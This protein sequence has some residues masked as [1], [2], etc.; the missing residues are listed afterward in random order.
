MNW[1]R[2]LTRAYIILWVLFAALGILV[3]T[4]HIDSLRYDRDRVSEYLRDNPGT[5]EQDLQKWIAVRA[6]PDTNEW[7]PEGA[8]TTPEIDLENARLDHV[9]AVYASNDYQH[10][11]VAHVKIWGLWLLICGAGPA[12][13]L[14]VT[15]WIVSGFKK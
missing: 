11:R 1:K 7:F 13:I 4:P 12:V 5:S 10:P 3:T 15:N 14:L 8:R 6:Q 2:G 9:L